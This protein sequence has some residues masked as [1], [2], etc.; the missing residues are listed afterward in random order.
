ML[1]IHVCPSPDPYMLYC[2]THN[3]ALDLLGLS[4]MQPSNIAVYTQH[5]LAAA[6]PSW[7]AGGFSC[8]VS[9]QTLGDSQCLP[10][11]PSLMTCNHYAVIWMS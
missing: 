1:Q 3:S 8:S 2:L 5:K 4:V 10:A 7:H 9:A 6:F 11:T